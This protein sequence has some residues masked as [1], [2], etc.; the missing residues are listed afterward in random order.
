MRLPVYLFEDPR[1]VQLYPFTRSRSA[2][3][4]RIGLFNLVERVQRI[5]P[6]AMVSI[7][8]RQHV[9]D[10]IREEYDLATS[11]LSR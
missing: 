1:F 11:L 6:K 9:A 2:A 8:T 10:V 4:I 5:L 7:L 3:T